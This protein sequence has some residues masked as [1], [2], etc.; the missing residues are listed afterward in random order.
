MSGQV[1]CS[2]VGRGRQKSLGTCPLGCVPAVPHHSAGAGVGP[3]SSPS[4][5]PAAGTA[6][7]R[8]SAASSPQIAPG[9]L[10]HLHPVVLGTSP[11]C[12]G[13][14]VFFISCPLSCLDAPSPVILGTE[15]PTS[16]PPRGC[17]VWA[18]ARS[19]ASLSTSAVAHAEV[20]CRAR[21]GGRARNPV[22]RL[23][24]LFSCVFPRLWKLRRMSLG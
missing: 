4:A 15:R 10:R 6:G 18:P 3:G 5:R 14:G 12:G 23:L 7:A 2:L 16:S 24:D 20:V 1:Q 8:G 13:C 17:G 21:L 11:D 22:F 9:P 19:P